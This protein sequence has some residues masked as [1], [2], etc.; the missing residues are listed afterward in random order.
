M[1]TTKDNQF[2]L[3]TDNTDYSKKTSTSRESRTAAKRSHRELE[4]ETE[5]IEGSSNVSTFQ[6]LKESNLPINLY[7]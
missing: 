2:R 5:D 1:N 3:H 7:T 4:S 6:I